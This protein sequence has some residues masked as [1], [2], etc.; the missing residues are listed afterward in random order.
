MIKENLEQVKNTLRADSTLVAVSKTKPNALIEEAYQ[1]GQRIFGENKA[2]E[3]RDKA[4]VLPADIEWHFIGRL[5]TNK[6]KYV[7]KA[8]QLIHSVDRLK[9]AKA[10]NDEATKLGKVQEVLVQLNISLEDSKTGFNKEELEEILQAVKSYENI[11]VVGLMTMAPFV[12]DAEEVR[13]VFKAMKEI[14]DQY[15][16]EYNLKYLSMGMSND[17]QIALEEG[18]NMVRIG[19]SI[20]GAR[21]YNVSNTEG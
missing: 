3:L 9:L 14:Y 5:Q 15:Q 7:V 21:N 16:E 2:L 18:A 12:D 10:I 6:V 1:S 4:L 19:S 8:A 11:N 17:Y 20:F 13:Y